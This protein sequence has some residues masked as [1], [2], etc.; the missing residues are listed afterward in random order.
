MLAI[1]RNKLTLK[2][3]NRSPHYTSI[4]T[5]VVKAWV[6]RSKEV[7][8]HTFY[9]RLSRKSVRFI[10]G[11]DYGR[12]I[13]GRRRKKVILEMANCACG[14]VV[15]DMERLKEGSAE[16]EYYETGKKTKMKKINN[17][18]KYQRFL[19][20]RRKVNKKQKKGKKNN[21]EMT[22]NEKFETKLTKNQRYVRDSNFRQKPLS[23]SSL[24]LSSS[25]SSFSSS[26]S[27]FSST[28]PRYLIM[29]KLMGR[30]MVVMMMI[31]QNH[32]IVPQ[33]M[34]VA[35]NN[36]KSICNNFG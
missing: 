28:S 6:H 23:L 4:H 19:N 25:L 2:H 33:A 3:V 5:T 22:K 13:L 36:R 14:E 34:K 20:S 18:K 8:K 11:R 30:K 16:K 12:F 17:N 29:M 9:I 1:H 26:S 35:R 31:P 27:S 15:E 7:Q 24:S 21:D 32:H 10:K